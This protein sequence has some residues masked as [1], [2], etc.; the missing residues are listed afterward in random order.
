MESDYP[1]RPQA[2]DV[3]YGPDGHEV[4][5]EEIHYPHLS[6]WPITTA[7]G[8]AFMGAGLVTFSAV[9]LAGI[10]IFFFGLISW[11]QELRHERQSH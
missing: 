7:L 11:F 3:D 10:V 9:S 6:V 5:E 2:E 1:A 8:I 4:G